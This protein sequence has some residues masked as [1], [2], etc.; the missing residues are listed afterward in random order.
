M[1]SLLQL[2][3]GRSLE[4]ADEIEDSLSLFPVVTT[5][6]RGTRTGTDDVF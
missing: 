1:N 6:R 3:V 5:Y 2:F 4:E